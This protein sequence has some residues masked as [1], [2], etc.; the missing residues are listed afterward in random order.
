VLAVALV[1]N[2]TLTTL[3]LAWN[4]I[5]GEGTLALASALV[6]NRTIQAVGL[7]GVAGVTADI[8]NVVADLLRVNRLALKVPAWV[9]SAAAKVTEIPYVLGSG[10]R[11]LDLPPGFA[12]GFAASAAV[13]A[14]GDE[15]LDQVLPAIKEGS[16]ASTGWLTPGKRAF[17]AAYMEAALIHELQRLTGAAVQ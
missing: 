5:G 11:R 14:F 8:K 12:A 9:V 2:A 7:E 13:F 15:L 10:H 6:T 4:N 1:K 16:E 3:G 17:A